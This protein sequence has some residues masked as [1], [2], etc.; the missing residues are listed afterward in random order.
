MYK[1]F[2]CLPSKFLGFPS[3]GFGE[4]FGTNVWPTELVLYFSILGLYLVKSKLFNLSWFHYFN[5]LSN[6]FQLL[7]SNVLQVL[8]H[9][10]QQL[11]QIS[12]KRPI[13]SCYFIGFLLPNEI[14]CKIVC[15]TKDMKIVLVTKT[16]FPTLQSTI[17]FKMNYSRVLSFLILFSRA[18]CEGNGTV[19]G[20][21][22]KL[23]CLPK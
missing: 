21:A 17:S 12:L 19:R 22:G 6:L 3:Y 15:L 4:S 23:L 13:A 10:P 8:K 2:I 16:I 9:G 5:T 11:G 18:N 7:V 1:W 20:C 14:I